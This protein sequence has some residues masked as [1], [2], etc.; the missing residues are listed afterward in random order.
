MD[1]IETKSFFSYLYFKFKHK[2]ITFLF[3]VTYGI[4]IKSNKKTHKKKP[5]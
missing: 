2:N 3:Y 1:S 4:K 5:I